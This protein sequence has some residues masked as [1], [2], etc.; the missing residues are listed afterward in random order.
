MEQTCLIYRRPL[1]AEGYT[2][3]PNGNSTVW[4]SVR[5]YHTLGAYPV[6][7]HPNNL[8]ADGSFEMDGRGPWRSNSKENRFYKSCQ[9]Q[10][11]GYPHGEHLP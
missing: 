7:K 6:V 5:C 2:S 10:N 9:Q 3:T 8:I 4:Y 1:E 11:N